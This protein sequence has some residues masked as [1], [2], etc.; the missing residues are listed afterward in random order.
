MANAKQTSVS[1]LMILSVCICISFHI[2]HLAVNSHYNNRAHRRSNNSIDSNG[3]KVEAY[4]AI[5]FDQISNRCGTHYLRFPHL[6]NYIQVIF[7]R[8]VSSNIRRCSMMRFSLRHTRTKLAWTEPPS[9]QATPQQSTANTH[10]HT[11]AKR[12]VNTKTME[13]YR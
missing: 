3:K 8:N 11:H 5:T 4:T 12:N 13:Y 6:P 9:S 7:M 10:T 1:K 2:D